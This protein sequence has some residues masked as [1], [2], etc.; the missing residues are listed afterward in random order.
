[1]R[2]K[3]K[4]RDIDEER[5]S[6]IVDKFKV[7]ELLATVLV[8]RGIVDDNEIKVFL[9]PTRNDFHDPYLMPDMKSA[10]KR[11]IQAINNNEKTIIYGDYDVD[12]VISTYILYRAISKCNGNVSFHIP[13]RIK[14]GYG[15]NESIIKKAK[16]ENVDI[17]ITCD[18]G[19]A[20]IEQVK[21]AK[22]L[23]LK[24]IITDHHDVP[25]IEENQKRKY[26]VPCA[27]FVIN[28][29]QENCTYKFDKICGAGVA[30]K[31]IEELYK[32]FGIDKEAFFQVIEK[33][34]YD[35][36]ESGSPQNTRRTVT[37]ADV[38]QMYRNLW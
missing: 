31:F 4:Y 24:V 28:P 2:K 5:V 26:V 22:D 38:E 37:Q 9:E 30:Y 27:D 15:I 12:G 25:F 10:V 14:E 7:S 21:L 20:A 19:I 8:N 6:R 36:M 35:A 3:W 1:M 23:G 11:I 16:D 13:D 33:M 17:I 18:N 32:E 29:K 34:A